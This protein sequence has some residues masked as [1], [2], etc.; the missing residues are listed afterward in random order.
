MKRVLLPAVAIALAVAAV[1][2]IPRAGAAPKVTN[3]PHGKFKGECSLCHGPSSWTQLKLS[4]KF[5]HASYGMP[6]EGA[7]ATNNCQSCHTSL[8]FSTARAQCASC[9]KDP[10]RGEMG[11]D[12]A[13]CHNSRSFT[14][15][16][17]MVRAHEM[18][19]FPLSGSHASVACESCHKGTGQGQLQFAGTRADCANC[20][21]ADYRA[22]KSPDHA[23][24]GFP[25]DCQGCHTAIEWTSATFDHSKTAFP[26]TGAHVN[27]HCAQCH[28]G[29]DFKSASTDCASCH[30]ND[31]THAQPDHAS[32]GFA[33]SQCATCHNT[34]TFA[35]AV[36]DH[37]KTQFPLTGAHVTTACASC[38]GDK[39]YAGKSTDCYACHQAKYASATPTHTAAAFPT[40]QCKTCHSTSSWSTAFDHSKTAFPLTGVHVTTACASC[41]GDGV[42]AGKSTTCYSCH[43]AKYAAATPP[44]NNTSF[45]QAQCSTCHSTA[46]W[47][48]GLFNHQVTQFPLTGAHVTAACSSCH[49]DGVY[50]AKSTDCYSCHQ[51]KYASATPTHNA[52]AFPTNACKTCHGTSTWVTTFNHS[53]T[54]FPLTGAHVGAAC[55]SCHND[56]VYDGKSTACYSCHQAKYASASPP[57]N[58]T[59]F[60]QAQCGTCHS[61]STWQNG[62]FNHSL[63]KFPLTGA[64]VSTDCASCHGDGVYAGKSMDCYSCHQS[65]Y[66]S[67]TPTHTATAFPTNA[68]KTCHSTSTWVTTFNHST[69][70]FPLTG[71]HVGAACTSCHGDGVYDGKS[72]ACYSCHASTYASAT[73]THNN[74]SFPQAQCGTCHSTSTWQ[75]GLFNHSLTQ[76]PLTGAHVSTTCVQ[77][78]GDNV[79]AGK[80]TACYSCHASTYA[81]ATPV[82]TAA[83]F[84]TNACATCHSTSTWVTTFNHST[85]SFPLTGAHVGAACTACHNDG[86]YDGKSTA[87]YSCHASTYASATPTHNNTSFPQAQCGTCHSTSTWQNGLFNH[88]LTQFPLTGAHVSTTCVQCHGDNVYAGKS[89][90][91]YSCHASTYASATPPHAAASFP[92]NACATCHSTSTWVT[93][94]NHSTTSFPLTGAHVGTAC[95]SCHNDGV[96]D[97]KS[98]ACYS[99][100]QSDY[101]SATPTHNATSFPTS[102][103]A[104]CHSTSTWS[105][106]L[107][108]HANTSFPLTG[109]H[110]SAACSS[111]H[112]DNVYD[113]KSTACY[114]CHQAKYTT[115]TPP[116]TAASFPTNAC[117]T[118]HNTSTWV[119]TF[120]HSN[121]SFPLTGAHVSASCTSCHSDGVYDGK[122][123]ACLSCHQADWNSASPTHTEAFFPSAQCGTCHT[124]TT[125]STGKITTHDASWFKIYSGKHRSKWTVCADCHTAPSNLATFTCI[126]C[127]E[128]SNKTSVD[129]DHQGKSGYTYSATSCYSC[130]RNV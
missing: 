42:Y 124:T 47:S 70:S 128:H 125:W 12:C 19:R 57:H 84:P 114:S 66:A 43:Q 90:A 16:G 80:S 119:T 39:V 95:V 36:Y 77:C 122:S 35:D 45:P 37:S 108:N 69:T 68:C 50:A 94:F 78:H 111:C 15:R 11:T 5:D 25:T 14:D 9:H 88:S 22:T 21:M 17:P 23:A 75:N 26:L 98:T 58:N 56:G 113:G 41:H 76:F 101:A 38:H 65:K 60:P 82:H 99:C 71:A 89:T 102:Q 63:T 40:A 72:T 1:V 53:T 20:H 7:H 129:K 121:T 67:A 62:L 96:Y 116:H 97:G 92:T 85:T 120:N 91:C 51:A 44:H 86:V 54:S 29:S 87:C 79:Y 30:N 83:A 28:S 112:G 46:T 32:A 93:T 49:G 74:T 59:S 18:T 115:A 100:H 123:T 127:H 33:A 81:T 31:Y 109:A 4:P 64:H 61:T 110:V 104:V 27:A 10:H 6:L 48:G 130:H 2:A 52:T 126:A 118:C 24:S 55:T 105:G 106:G 117:A 13:R 8:D 107:F 34:R 73:P 3:N 103:C